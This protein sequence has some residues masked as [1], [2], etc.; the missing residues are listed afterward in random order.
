MQNKKINMDT[1]AYDD[2]RHSITDSPPFITNIEGRT[3]QHIQYMPFGEF[4][5]SQRNTEFDSRYKFTAKELDNELRSNRRTPLKI[6]IDVRQTNYTYF[7]ARYYDS[8]LSMWL[9]VDPMADQR[10]LVSPYSYCQNSPINRVD[11]TG[12]LDNPIYDLNGNFLGTD[13]DGLKGDAIIMNA[14]DFKQGM[15]HDDAITKGK[16]LDNMSNEQALKFA[17]N[18]NFEKFLGHYNSLS[19]RPDWNGHLTLDEANNW[20]RNGNGQAL[21]T[22]LSKI[23]LSN[24]Y[25]KGEKYVNQEKYISLF[26][27]SNSTNDALVYGQITLKRYPNHQVRAYS[28]E[29]NFET[30]NPWNPLNW[31]RNIQTRIGRSYAGDGQEYDINIYGSKTLK[32]LFPWTK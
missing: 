16:T 19:S 23:D 32:P 18:G 8:D 30:H 1:Y 10:S 27:A 21:Y 14:S 2:F 22:D 13:D 6:I 12:A 20:Y 7:G 29:Y 4:F 28:D 15:S 24:L 5:V 25:S 3:E 31:P 11:P 17:N 9:S 26:R